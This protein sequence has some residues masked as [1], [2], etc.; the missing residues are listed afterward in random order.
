MHCNNQ[1]VFNNTNLRQITIRQSANLTIEPH[2]CHCLL[3]TDPTTRWNDGLVTIGRLYPTSESPPI[4]WRLNETDASQTEPL[5]MIGVKFGYRYKSRS[6]RSVLYLVE[7]DKISNIPI[8]ESNT[9]V[10]RTGGNVS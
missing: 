2:E 10:L 7:E 4:S 8:V 1:I 5:S 9:I 6:N 3:H